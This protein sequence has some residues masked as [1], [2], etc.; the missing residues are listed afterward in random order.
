MEQ[1]FEASYLQYFANIFF[2]SHKR[3]EEKEILQTFGCL[4][5]RISARGADMYIYDIV[6][7]GPHQL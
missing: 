2:A 3:N 4:D 1:P 5:F 7:T 6:T